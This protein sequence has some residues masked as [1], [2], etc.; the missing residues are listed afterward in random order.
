[1][2][3][4]FNGYV[5]RR[6][7]NSPLQLE[8]ED[9]SWQ[10]KNRFIKPVTAD[11]ATLESFIK[12]VYDGKIGTIAQGRRKIGDW[13]VPKLSTFLQILDTLRNTFGIT[14]YWDLDGA[15]NIDAQLEQLSTVQDR[16]YQFSKNLINADGMNFEEAAEYSQIVHYSSIQDELNEE[17]G[18][19]IENVEVY[20]FY[21]QNGKIQSKET[22]P[23]LQGNINRFTIPYFTYDELKK[24][25]EARLEKLNFTG[26]RGRFLTF[27]EPV[28]NVNDDCQIINI[29]SPEMTGRYRIKGVEVS[30]DINQG[31]KQDIEVARKTG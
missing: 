3:R 16:I 4:R 24:L 28:A 7:P 15:L 11:D 18:T 19:P 22:D 8:C 31:Y 20:S 13:R 21:D 6:V 30:Y 23:G 26:Y 9:E 1:M 12:S 17:D 10:W 5:T 14:A 27:G 29:R 25:S 2:V